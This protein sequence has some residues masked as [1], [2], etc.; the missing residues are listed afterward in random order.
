MTTPRYQRHVPLIARL[1][2]IKNLISGILAPFRRQVAV[3]TL[4]NLFSAAFPLVM[5]MISARIVDEG[6]LARNMGRFLSNAAVGAAVFLAGVVFTSFGS[7]VSNR[8]T[9]SLRLRLNRDLL[10]RLLARDLPFFRAETAKEKIF[11]LFDVENVISLGITIVPSLAADLGKLLL[12]FVVLFFIDGRFVFFLILTAPVFLL[13]TAFFR[14]KLLAAYESIWKLNA[15]MHRKLYE[16]FERIYLV[17]S[18]GLERYVRNSYIKLLIAEIRSRKAA[19]MSEAMGRISSVFLAKLIYAAAA[20]FGCVLVIEGKVSPGKYTAVMLYVMYAG[21][22]IQGIA[23]RIE[24]AS[25]EMVSVSRFNSIPVLPGFAP[26]SGRVS[27]LREGIE[28]R[29][30]GFGY[31][32]GTPVVDG[33]SFFIPAAALAALVG[34]TG[35]GKTTLVNLILKHYEAEKGTVYWDGV[36]IRQISPQAL[37]RNSAVACQEPF[38]TSGSLRENI[39]LD[40]RTTG[41]AK[42]TEWSE[43]AGL[44]E[45]VLSLPHGYDT[46]IGE[47]GTVLS[48]GLK[49]KVALARALVRQPA[50]LILDEALSSLDSVSERQILDSLREK[51]K[52]LL[53]LVISHRLSTIVGSDI[54]FFMRNGRQVSQGTH[55]QLLSDAG[56]REHFKGQMIQD[57]ANGRG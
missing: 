27:V 25:R 22:T 12:I 41:E 3:M 54:I 31:M 1:D 21:A 29:D 37:R 49:Q 39:L 32:P 43:A 36:D 7:F 5:P 42:L 20:V 30:A 48:N 56:Y 26:A 4:I 52:G 11:M 18:L 28:I 15:A 44:H 47:G 57:L 33:I 8:F 19:F 50:V 14:K 35:C 13:K 17:K 38:L 6:L 10:N 2:S 53:T 34:P 23:D 46:V 9:L 24:M 51:R 55:E 45:Y 16:S 40:M